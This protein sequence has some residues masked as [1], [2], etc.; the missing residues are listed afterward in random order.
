MIKPNLQHQQNI[1]M[2]NT[3]KTKEMNKKTNFKNKTSQVSNLL[4]KRKIFKWKNTMDVT[5]QSML[6]HNTNQS[7]QNVINFFSNI[8]ILTRILMITE[9][10]NASK[11]YEKEHK[12]WG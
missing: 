12:L 8:H 2:K 9:Y 1:N 6:F 10:Y 11:H 7:I 3:K 4:N 5:L